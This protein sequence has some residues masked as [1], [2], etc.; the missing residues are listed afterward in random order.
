MDEQ[1]NSQFMHIKCSPTIYAYTQDEK[2][3]DRIKK[4]HLIKATCSNIKIILQSG[5]FKKYY[6]KP[7]TAHIQK[8]IRLAR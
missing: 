7:L 4:S 2:M 1:Q 5:M 3:Q 8:Q 6:K